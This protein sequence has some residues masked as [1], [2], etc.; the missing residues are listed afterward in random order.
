MG[1][2]LHFLVP[3]AIVHFEEHNEVEVVPCSWLTGNA[4]KWPTLPTYKVERLIRKGCHPGNQCEEMEVVVK[5]IFKC[6]EDARK[7]LPLSQYTSDLSATE[8]PPKRV[9]RAR[10]IDSDEDD[11]FPPVPSSFVAKDTSVCL[12][13]SSV[14]D[15]A[16]SKDAMDNANEN[17]GAVQLDARNSTVSWADADDDA[18][19]FASGTFTPMVGAQ[20][21]K[22]RGSSTGQLMANAHLQPAQQQHGRGT[23]GQGCSSVTSAPSVATAHAWP[24][25]MMMEEYGYSP[26]TAPSILTPLQSPGQQHRQ[27]M[28]GQRSSSVT[29]TPVPTAGSWPREQLMEEY[30]YYTGCSPTTT[31]PPVSSGP[32]QPPEQTDVRISEAGYSPEPSAASVPNAPTL[33]TK[34]TRKASTFPVSSAPSRPSKPLSQYEFQEQVLVQFRVLR[35]TL[36]EHGALLEGLVP[37]RTTLIEETKLLPQPM[38]TVEEVD[39]FEQQLTRDR[40]KQLVGELS[41]LGGNTVKSSVRR[42]MSHILSDELGQLY[43]WEGRK[44]KLKFLELK[45]PSIILRALHTH[46]KLSKATEFEVEAAIKE[47]LRHAPQRCKRGQP[48]C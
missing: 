33:P 37:L 22:V 32:L 7:M 6:Y 14:M 48:G 21:H 2:L 46:K 15:K 41:L 25:E 23:A 29:S 39:E 44:G 16:G 24:R 10:V 18:D 13:S 8:L 28:T 3:Y 11:E 27:G 45:F 30:S 26:R 43:S 12:T 4:C 40:E 17:M 20:Q 42:I 38:K 1:S 34:P 35:A 9:R 31:V 36:M 5:G 19:V 47:W